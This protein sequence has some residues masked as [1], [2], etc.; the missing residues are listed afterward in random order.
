MSA[1][2]RT[3]RNC[4]TPHPGSTNDQRGLKHV[5]RY[6]RLSLGFKILIWLIFGIGIGIA[7]GERAVALQPA[8]DL[9]I[10]M[11]LMAA[12]P[13]VFFNLIAGITSLADIRILG[14]YGVRT[15][16]YYF[17]TTAMALTLGLGMAHV[18]RPGEGMQ[19]TDEVDKSFGEMPGLVQVILDLVPSN[20]FH[21]FS[22]GN[23][24]RSSCLQYSLA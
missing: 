1:R 9:F 19:L 15:M 8:G 12:I 21:A 10:R 18:F 4:R 11:L 16:A 3:L 20:V 17:A 5:G 2:W 13:L 7:F 22:S 6:R 23:V 24:S 14:R